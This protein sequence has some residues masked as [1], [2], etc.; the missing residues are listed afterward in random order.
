MIQAIYALLLADFI[1]GV[2]HWLEDRYGN[3]SWP[4]LGKWVVLPNIL[5]HEDPKA[6]L[7]GSYWHRNCTTIIPATALAVVFWVVGLPYWA[8]GACLVL[9]QANQIHAWSHSKPPLIVQFLQRAN[10]L[11]RATD[12]H[13]HHRYPFNTDFCVI[14]P[15]LNPIL[16]G[17]RFWQVAE[18][19][20]SLAG[21]RP[22][23]DRN[24]LARVV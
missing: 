19:V 24:D 4:V 11:I 9:S 17:L 21:V 22:F 12:H 1:S 2:F 15:L 8:V 3:P 14:T 13:K 23:A 20:L 7:A 16:S 18:W 10:V 6:M 5:H